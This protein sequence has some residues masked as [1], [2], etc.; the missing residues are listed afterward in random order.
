[1][2]DLSWLD[3]LLNFISGGP[4][5]VVLTIAFGVLAIIFF[6]VM[7][8]RKRPYYQIKSVNIVKDFANM[9]E[10]LRIIHG[11][12]PVENVTVAKIAFWNGGNEVINSY[13]IAPKNPIRIRLNNGRRMLE[14]PKLRV[15][16]NEINGVTLGASDDGSQVVCAFDYLSRNEGFVVEIVHD[17]TSAPDLSF[18]GT[19]KGYDIRRA[20]K[21]RYVPFVIGFVLSLLAFLVFLSYEVQ[22][23]KTARLRA[24]RHEIEMMGI[25]KSSL[26]RMI[27]DAT[28][29][30]NLWEE[31]V[32]AKSKADPEFAE[33]RH[34]KEMEKN[35]KA[36]RNRIEQYQLER[37]ELVKKIAV[38]EM[39]VP[40]LE[41]TTAIFDLVKWDLAM[42]LIWF[43][44]S[45]FFCG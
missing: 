22:D 4:F 3:K 21:T 8:K 13:D 41:N 15:V 16:T 39:E 10:S 5:G 34:K 23:S 42:P 18:E 37:D 24:H 44:F 6:F 20:D 29:T 30:A 35:N 17:G 45:R 33:S 27:D 2:S 40:V 7:W 36:Y 14:Q 1:M 32:K 19:V 38:S 12:G 25:R 31:L 26:D 28:K 9:F 43:M 11:S